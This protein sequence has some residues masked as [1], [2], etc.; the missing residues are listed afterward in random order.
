MKNIKNVGIHHEVRRFIFHHD[1]GFNLSVKWSNHKE[2][3]ISL[4][5]KHI[6]AELN[7]KEINLHDW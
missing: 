2:P 5:I 4:Y 1:K 6:Q 3:N 7:R